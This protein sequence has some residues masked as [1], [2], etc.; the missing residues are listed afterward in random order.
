MVTKD[1][2][3]KNKNETEDADQGSSENVVVLPLNEDS[4]K[5]TQTLS[6][7]KSLKILDL[8]SE[9]P[10]SATDISKKLGLSITT[11]KY[12]I[13]SLLE[14]DL[15]KVHRIKWSAKGREVK[16]YE[17]VQKLI[18][19]APGN[20]NI[21]R[22]SIISMLQQYIGVIGAAFLGAAG[23]QYLS[24][25]VAIEN[26]GA[27]SAPAM[28]DVAMESE[29]LR[30]APMDMAP[31]LASDEVVEEVARAVPEA[32]GPQIMDSMHTF[33]SNLSD[34]IGL[35]FFLGC[36][37]AVMLM[38]LKGRYYDNASSST[39]RSVKR[40]LLPLMLVGVV[41]AALSVG[42]APTEDDQFI[43]PEIEKIPADHVFTEGDNGSIVSVQA[44]SIVRIDL[45]APSEGY[46]D[47][48][49]KDDLS[50]KEEG[51][52]YSSSYSPVDD[53][54][55]YGWT[56][57]TSSIGEKSI[58]VEYNSWNG[59]SSVP[60]DF[61]MTLIVEGDN[62]LYPSFIVD[63]YYYGDAIE[64]EQGEWMLIRLF[65]STADTYV[66]NMT[67]TEGLQVKGDKFIPQSEGS[68]YGMHE[69][70]IEAVAAGEQNISAINMQPEVNLTGYEQTFD[71]TV[72]VI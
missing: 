17:P 60:S 50:T 32:A 21:S 51:Y 5:I 16:L 61:E 39:K 40:Y 68:L 7:E 9:E 18:I 8:L 3:N 1:V 49:G 69:W 64:L 48:S 22:A 46:W 57:E 56:F 14:S 42:M 53:D 4:K 27:F 47:L 43:Y 65:E 19:V 35:W 12:N 31:S 11:I 13:D 44:G 26:G 63:G 25:P 59:Q 10:M 36:L 41:I 62:E 72:R 55:V 23:L 54:S 6:N 67:L 24:K 58:M 66:W 33:F 30:D 52:G 45:D 34:N 15:I 2:E 38:M 20:M 71:L 70:K 37:F 28:M 29:V